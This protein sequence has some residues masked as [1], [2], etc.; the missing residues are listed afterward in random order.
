[1]TM[2]TAERGSLPT[3]MA[4]GTGLS[5]TRISGTGRPIV[6]QSPST[7]LFTRGWSDSRLTWAPT[8]RATVPGA[9]RQST[10][11]PITVI[12]TNAQSPTSA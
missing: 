8:D 7:R 12:A 1:M 10:N 6:A 2:T 9:R 5:T 3:A 11:D 4:F